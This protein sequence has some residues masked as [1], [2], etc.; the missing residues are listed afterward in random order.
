MVQPIQLQ[1]LKV[2]P[3]MKIILLALF[4]LATFATEAQLPKSI[5]ANDFVMECMKNSGEL[6]H[7]EM[8]I[9]IPSDFLKIIGDEMKLSPEG[10][11][12]LVTEMDKYMMFCIVD[13]T[14]VNQQLV[15]ETADE[16]RSS[17]KLVDSAKL[18][19]LPLADK[20]ISPSASEFINH[21][22]P[23]IAKILGQFGDGMRMFLFDAR[24]ANG[25]PS[26]DETKSNHFA[27]TWDQ[28]SMTWRLPF[29]S[30]LPVKYC[31]VDNEPMKG[32]WNYCPY[33]GVKLN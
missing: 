27:L 26:F 8:V 24:G 12:N 6:P 20:D 2:T 5:N 18:I 3:V 19:Y 9:W 30:V 4:S 31:P 16:I 13:V 1:H 23:V 32:N 10:V 14:L 21:F 22:Q 25:N 17:L 29:A 33:H 11:A 15:F 28:V 7:K